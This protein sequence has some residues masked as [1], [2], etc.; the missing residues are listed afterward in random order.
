MVFPFLRPWY[1][2][3]GSTPTEISQV[4]PGDDLVESP[5]ILT[6]R[7]ITINATPAEVWPWIIQ[8]GN[9]RAGWYN[10]DL[11]NRII[12]DTNYVDGHSSTRIVPELQNLKTGDRIKSAASIFTVT[13]L[14]PNRLLVLHA[15]TDEQNRSWVYLLEAIDGE[16][17]RLIVRHKYHFTGFLS[18]G[19]QNLLEPAAFAMERKHLLGIKERAENN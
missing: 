4:I 7:S 6:S 13:E 5:K 2:N 19:I 1:Y 9:E 16:Q 18:N 17:T 11:V 15:K 14:D 3:W 12:G 10:Y 8:L